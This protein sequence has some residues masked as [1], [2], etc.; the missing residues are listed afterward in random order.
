MH[1]AIDLL[2][3][4]MES[5]PEEF[6]RTH[7]RQTKW[8]NL[9]KQYQS[10]MS[11]EE[12]NALDA[13]ISDIMLN[14]LHQQ[15]MAELLHGESEY[16]LDELAN[17]VLGRGTGMYKF[18]PPAGNLSQPFINAQKEFLRN[19]LPNNLTSPKEQS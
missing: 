17:E 6:S 19:V 4:R 13:K 11:E 16:A 8:F 10:Y 9:I 3:K 18:V 12:R 7:I 15:V 1:P 14:D 5:N 2:L